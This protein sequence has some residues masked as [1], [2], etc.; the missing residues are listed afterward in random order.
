MKNRDQH[1]VAKR[2]A[3]VAQTQQ[4]I[5]ATI[6]AL[7]TQLAPRQLLE[8]TGKA[9]AQGAEETTAQAAQGIHD[10]ITKIQQQLPDAS[11]VGAILGT[12][13]T[14][15]GSLAQQALHTG[16]STAHSV[17]QNAHIDT[18][19]LAAQIRDKVQQTVGDVQHHA[20]ETMQQAQ[21]QVQREFQQIEHLLGDHPW[22]MGTL[23][24][25]VG[26]GIGL[27]FPETDT[28]QK[29]FSSSRDALLEKVQASLHSLF[30]TPP[31]ETDLTQSS[32][33]V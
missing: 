23:S 30:V 18:D 14:W 24:L 12:M 3:E 26:V 28:E 19:Q 15:L 16:Q 21:Q 2:A 8:A 10:A 29:W 33:N 32:A 17:A 25:L 31:P 9:L 4:D 7:Q 6:A 22:Q 1:S 11:L 13:S 27:A 20:T 5:A